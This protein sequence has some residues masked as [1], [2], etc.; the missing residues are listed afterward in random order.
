MCFGNVDDFH[1]E[2]SSF[3]A[4]V[5]EKLDIPR[6][7]LRLIV[8]LRPEFLAKRQRMGTSRKYQIDQLHISL[9]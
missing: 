1:R 2:T 8:R 3:L 7:R 4:K 5:G 9:V 6:L